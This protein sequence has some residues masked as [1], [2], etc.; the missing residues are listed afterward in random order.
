M[1]NF[2]SKKK[3]I[4]LLHRTNTEESIKDSIKNESD[5]ENGKLNN[6]IINTKDDDDDENSINFKY[7]SSKEIINWIYKLNRDER[8]KT[9]SITNNK[10]SEL[11]QR[12][13]TKFTTNSKTKFKLTFENDF[14]ILIH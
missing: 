6:I 10:L 11:I 14:L 4:K 1:T 8:T 13:Y 12:M 2:P 3:T 5:E 9:F 7:I